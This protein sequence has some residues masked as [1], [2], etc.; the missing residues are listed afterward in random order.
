MTSD[1]YFRKAYEAC[2]STC[3]GMCGNL[4]AF[5][6]CNLVGQFRRCPTCGNLRQVCTCNGV[7]EGRLNYPEAIDASCAVVEPERPVPELG[8]AS[9]G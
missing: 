2:G 5:C 8:R 7:D 4:A 3:C 6:T 1:A 9:G